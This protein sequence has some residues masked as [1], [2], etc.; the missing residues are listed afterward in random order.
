M[1]GWLPTVSGP[2]PEIVHV[3]HVAITDRYTSYYNGY[4]TNV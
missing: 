1:W 2:I 3:G 4:V